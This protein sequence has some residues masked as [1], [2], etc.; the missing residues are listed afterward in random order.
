MART[1]AA[2]F[3]SALFLARHH[4][5]GDLRPWTTLTTGLP[6]VLHESDSERAL[7][8][9]VAAEQGSGAGLVERS[10]LHG[11][12]DVL[13]A[14]LGPGD[15]LLMDAGVY[16]LA[17][18]ACRAA[19]VRATAYP[20]HSPPRGPLPERTWFLTDGWCQGCG[21]PAPLGTLRALAGASGGQ[22]IVDDSLA[23]GVLGKR[24]RGQEFGDGS[25]TVRY[26]GADHAGYVWL[27]SLAKAYGTPLTVITGSPDTMQRIADSGS[28][29]M[30]S[31]PPSAA[32]VA[33]GLDSLVC[34]AQLATERN[35]LAEHTQWLRSEYTRIQLP[36]QGRSF[37][38]VS[39]PMADLATAR[40][41]QQQLARSGINVL[42]QQ[43]RCRRTPM[44][45]AVLRS[46]H[47]R[48]DLQ[49]LVRSLE[50]IATSRKAA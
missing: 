27:A 45:S 6:A 50:R 33:A 36:C 40:W 16:P 11:L 31:S 5:S 39:T 29:R 26:C 18:Q 35:R 14:L 28:H 17:R 19:G 7:A 13:Q 4:P 22:V 24:L 20:H 32:D 41:W 1:A 42:V 47:R 8:A 43:P 44:L 15:H 23:Y 38:I 37:P 9:M 30:H 21:S 48:S 25:G 2:D 10:A 46:D 3:T 49:G 34:T 12:I